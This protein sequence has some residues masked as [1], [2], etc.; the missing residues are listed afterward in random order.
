MSKHIFENTQNLLCTRDRA[1]WFCIV[2]CAFEECADGIRSNGYFNITAQLIRQIKMLLDKS[3][4]ERS[5]VW[6][7]GYSG[8]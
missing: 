1:N 3:N 5:T 8:I 7:Y 2:F 4:N 6:V